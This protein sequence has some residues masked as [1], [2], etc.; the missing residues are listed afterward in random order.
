MSFPARRSVSSIKSELLNPALTSHFY[1]RFFAPRK[2]IEWMQESANLGYGLPYTDLTNF[3]SIACMDASLP[4]SSLMTHEQNNDFHGVTQRIAYRRDYGTGSDF[5]FIVDGGHYLIAFF[6][7]WIRYI[8]NEKVPGQVGQDG[9][10]F[11]D[12]PYI[13]DWKSYSRVNYFNDYVTDGLY[14]QKFERDYQESGGIQ[15]NFLRAYPISISAMPISYEG[16]QLLKCTVTFTYARYYA[17]PIDPTAPDGIASGPV[18]DGT[19][20]APDEELRDDWA[21]WYMTWGRSRRDILTPTQLNFGERVERR[22]TSDPSYLSGLRERARLGTYTV[23]GPT[24]R[25]G[26][27]PGPLIPAGRPLGEVSFISTP[28]SHGSTASPTYGRFGR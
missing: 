14:I 8:V 25:P 15:Y 2:V 26:S 1:C 22:I 20:P 28:S 18:S 12:Y 5:T 27:G 13:T 11:T 7:N 3:V 19:P 23:P 10:S 24:D 9:E 21:I 4:G 17:S 6:E 16:S